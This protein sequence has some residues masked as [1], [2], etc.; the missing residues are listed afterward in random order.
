MLTH[1]GELVIYWTL[2]EV[3]QSTA[4]LLSKFSVNYVHITYK[5][6]YTRGYFYAQLYM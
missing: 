5:S 3:R 4:D 6:R 2:H 1:Y